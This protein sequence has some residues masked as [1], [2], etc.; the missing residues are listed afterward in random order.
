MGTLI[1]HRPAEITPTAS[2]RTAPR[3]SEVIHQIE[4]DLDD[5]VLL[6]RFVQDA[7][8]AAFEEI[9]KRYQKLVMSVCGR[10]LGSG[11]DTED[12]FQATFI[13]LARRPRS[14]RHSK[15]LSSWLY[16]VAYRISWRLVRH[17][18]KSLTENLDTEPMSQSTDPLDQISDAQDCVIVDEE[19][20]R[21]PVKFK[22]VL[23]MTYFAD[24]SSQQIADT[25]NVSKGTVDGRIR[26][27][28]NMLR[29]KLAR[30]GVTIGAIAL[31]ASACTEATAAASSTVLN[32]TL[33]LGSQTLAN[34][35]LSTPNLS[36]IN[37]LIRPETTMLSTKMIAATMLS[38]AAAGAIGFSG[39]VTA[40]Q[41]ATERSQPG[42]LTATIDATGTVSDDLPVKNPASTPSVIVG[43]GKAN[44]P[45]SN[46]NKS[47]KNSNPFATSDG[48]AA[49]NE[50]SFDPFADTD[51]RNAPTVA[52]PAYSHVPKDAS[53][54]EQRIYAALDQQTPPLDFPGETNLKEILSTVFDE[55]NKN[56]QLGQDV[57]LVVDYQQL[58]QEGLQP[59]EDILVRDIR[60][61][62]IPLKTAIKLILD[63]TE[64][65]YLVRDDVLFLTTHEEALTNADYFTTRI[66]PVKNLLAVQTT[67]D[68][69]DYG[70][71]EI[72]G[73]EMGMGG[74]GMGESEVSPA[75]KTR[76]KQS[77]GGLNSLPVQ[78][79]GGGIDNYGM[80]GGLYVEPNHHLIQL[81]RDMTSP[82]CLW[83]D[84]DGQGGAISITGNSLVVRQSR[85][86][87]DEIVKLL[88]LLANAKE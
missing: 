21:L 7:D 18:K 12:A 79:G 52:K 84:M 42:S 26:D 29:V 71:G 8:E 3:V 14:I 60:L 66:Y 45:N 28:R 59:Y 2:E 62:G 9:V 57:T 15:A 39:I 33:Q 72:M 23:V 63:Q 31:A 27:A 40:Q 34:H 88:N 6:R 80:G 68:G 86:G 77:G 35:A 53:S 36:R 32:S 13:C 43:A 61:S 78:F 19:L 50:S 82:P 65:D 44:K 70:M 47:T 38:I 41:N 87:H 24:Q 73:G 37:H 17:R 75:N 1:D 58:N 85:R 67:T 5:R 81:V 10:I 46:G 55:V 51:D 11:Q 74:M 30:R 20:N 69:G 49:T 16:T 54:A 76:R 83:L 56:A 64:I 4:Q 25:L 22:D 48:P